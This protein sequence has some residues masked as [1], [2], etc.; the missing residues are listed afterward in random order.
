MKKPFIKIQT[1]NESTIELY[2]PYV[3][4][5]CEEHSTH[6]QFFFSEL[7]T[8]AGYAIKAFGMVYITAENEPKADLNYCFYIEKARPTA[9]DITK[10]INDAIKIS[11]SLTK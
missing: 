8:K 4:V 7:L 6:P 3:M 11:K 5:W 1:G 9:A 2:M 10:L